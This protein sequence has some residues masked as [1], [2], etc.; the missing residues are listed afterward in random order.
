MT[1]SAQ[2]SRR[3]RLGRPRLLPLLLCGVCILGAGVYVLAR[4]GA[5]STVLINNP[6]G[7]RS[8]FDVARLEGL[9]LF[10]LRTG[11][12]E[13]FTL[14]SEKTLVILASAGDCPTC[15]DER[16]VWEELARAADERR[17]RVVAVLVRTSPSEARTFAKAY[18]P[19]FTLLLDR[20]DQLAQRTQL[21]QLT[22]FKLLVNNRGGILMTD[23]PNNK[24]LAQEAFRGK[25]AAQIGLAP[26]AR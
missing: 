13:P 20:E 8:T 19:P 18:D 26:A 4:R 21:P 1:S 3:F 12:A 10:D 6:D 9:E 14:T 2:S 15:L 11:R 22:P 25:V 5:P 24:P 16:R 7:T 23:G 17:F